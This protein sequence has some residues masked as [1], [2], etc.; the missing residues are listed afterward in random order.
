MH[1]VFLKEKNYHYMFSARGT[2]ANGKITLEEEVNLNGPVEVFVTFLEEE[3]K[4]PKE[5]KP[6]TLDDFSFAE[7]KK[8]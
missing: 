6:L 8:R 7:S 3:K 1:F 2:Y 5:G 4:T